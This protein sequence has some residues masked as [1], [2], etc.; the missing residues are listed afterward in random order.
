MVN[1]KRLFQGGTGGFV[2][3]EITPGQGDK[4]RMRGEPGARQHRKPKGC[5]RDVS[6]KEALRTQVSPTGC[7]VYLMISRKFTET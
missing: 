4:A 7:K 2:N 6:A 5:F 1:A 3:V